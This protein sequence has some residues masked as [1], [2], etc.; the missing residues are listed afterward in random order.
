MQ[1]GESRGPISKIGAR[2]SSRLSFVV[3]WIP[4]IS[5]RARS[6]MRQSY[7]CRR[8]MCNPRSAV[9]ARSTAQP[10]SRRH[11]RTNRANLR[12]G[13]TT[14]ILILSV[15]P[16]HQYLALPDCVSPSPIA[17][18]PVREFTHDPELRRPR[19]GLSVRSRAHW[20]QEIRDRPYSGC[21]FY[22]L[23]VT[24]VAWSF[25]GAAHQYMGHPLR[26]TISS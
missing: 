4:P 6:T 20:Q 2:S 16:P 7:G 18:V 5:G 24:Y 13:S 25:S 12:S 1:F 14:R 11:I 8:V 22:V 10:S 17:G 15:H 3:S 26:F 19:E 23:V 9:A 21:G